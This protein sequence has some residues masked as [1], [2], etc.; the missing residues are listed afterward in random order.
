MIFPVT[1]P[2]P[3]KPGCALTGSGVSQVS[4][5]QRCDSLKKKEIQQMTK[6]IMKKLKVYK[7]K[8]VYMF[9]VCLTVEM[10]I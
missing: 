8:N 5:R 10:H 3:I 7:K 2:A 1:T 9:V 4:G 6:T